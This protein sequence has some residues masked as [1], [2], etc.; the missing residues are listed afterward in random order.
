MRGDILGS[1]SMGGQ[2]G[3]IFARAVSA[4]ERLAVARSIRVGGS[5]WPSLCENA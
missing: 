1:G 3:P 4:L 2:L 5:L